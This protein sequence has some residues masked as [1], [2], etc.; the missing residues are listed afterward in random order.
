MQKK[1]KTIT[2]AIEYGDGGNAKFC[3]LIKRMKFRFY[4]ESL[5]LPFSF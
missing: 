4:H 1:T 5:F 3:V 2:A